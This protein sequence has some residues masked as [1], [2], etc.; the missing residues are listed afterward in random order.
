MDK[1][2]LQKQALVFD[3]TEKRKL[4]A[5]LKYCKHRFQYHPDCGI[6]ACGADVKFVDYLLDNL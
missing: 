5:L 3:G 2:T 6:N 4:I 1:I